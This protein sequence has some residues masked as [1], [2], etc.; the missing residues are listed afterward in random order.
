[1]KAIKMICAILLA[2][3]VSTQVM[4]ANYQIDTDEGHVTILFRAGHLG[5]SFNVGRF[6][7]F[8][9]IFNHDAANPGNSKVSVV[10]DA[11]SVDTNHAERDKHLRSDD[12]LDVGK[13]PTI[14]FES[15]SYVAGS[16]GDK[17]NGNLSI[18]GVTKPVTINVKHIGEGKDPW[19]GYRSGFQGLITF[20]A[21]DY[22]MPDWVGN[23]EVELIVEGVRQDS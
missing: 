20:N 2:G 16:D 1:M 4:A 3:L 5:Y 19:G 23:L 12:F 13:Y 6:N 8:K 11:S 14:T 22:G 21:A 15:T 10:I 17:L 7:D 9:G 18:H